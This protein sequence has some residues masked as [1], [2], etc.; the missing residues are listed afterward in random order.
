M[1]LAPGRVAA[2]LWGAGQEQRHYL[3]GRATQR[4][5]EAGSLPQ[6][7]HCHP[8]LAGLDP[9]PTTALRLYGPGLLLPELVLTLALPRADALPAHR[10]CRDTRLR[11]R[12]LRVPA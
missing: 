9:P 12:L 1:G 2:R 5:A 11:P 6:R 4:L 10:F 7:S 8:L 3:T